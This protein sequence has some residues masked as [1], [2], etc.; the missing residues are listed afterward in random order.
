[1]RRRSELW[2]HAEDL[3]EGINSA[4]HW[5]CHESNVCLTRAGRSLRCWLLTTMR[6]LM[7]LNC[8][9]YTCMRVAG[10]LLMLLV[11]RLLNLDVKSLQ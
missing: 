4:T 7:R 11:L 6:M 8:N 1:M 9:S 5:R 2:H 3:L 10:R